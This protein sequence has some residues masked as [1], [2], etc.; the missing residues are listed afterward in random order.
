VVIDTGVL[1]SAF[2]FGGIP[3]KAIR[4]AF[5]EA[6]IYVSPSLL[7]EYRDVPLVLED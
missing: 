5:T 6:D 7:K 2:V 1:I 4:K 3:E